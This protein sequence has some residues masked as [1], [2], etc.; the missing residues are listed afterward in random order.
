MSDS[1][2]PL[3]CPVC[4]VSMGVQLSKE[5]AELGQRRRDILISIPSLLGFPL[6]VI[7]FLGFFRYSNSQLFGDYLVIFPIC[8]VS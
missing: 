7:D 2:A 1:E 8:F 6:K 4:L 3:L 5:C